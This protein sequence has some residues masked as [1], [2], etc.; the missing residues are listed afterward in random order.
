MPAKIKDEE[1]VG[2][3]F[4]RLTVIKRH[5]TKDQ[6]EC[7]CV[8]SDKILIKSGRGIRTGQTKS[9]GCLQREHVAKLNANSLGVP[10]THGMTDTKEYIAWRNMKARCDD[11]NHQAYHN[12]G[13]RGISYTECWKQF[14]SFYESMGDCPEGFSLDRINTMSDYSEDN[15]E[16]VPMV[17]QMQHRRKPKSGRSSRYKGV[18][19]NK[20]CGKYKGTLKYLGKCYHLGYDYCEEVLARRYDELLL[21]LSGDIEGTNAALGLFD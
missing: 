20:A 1:M 12:Y 5:G 2:I 16:W 9:C 21:E 6:W 8:C 18:S 19:F 3:T 13:G 10:K 4:N 11:P 17:S 15:C 14:E 7:R